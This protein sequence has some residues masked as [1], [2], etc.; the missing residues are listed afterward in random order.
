[1]S[2]QQPQQ[3]IAGDKSRP[4][5]RKRIRLGDLLVENNVISQQQLKHALAEQKVRGTRLGRTLIDLGYIDEKGLL[6]FLSRQLKMPFIDLRHYQLRAQTVK[7]LPETLARRFRAI[8]LEAREQGALVGLADPTDIFAQDELARVLKRPIKPA[9]V[10]EADL[11]DAFDKLYR[12]TDEISSIAEEL[13]EQISQS[14]FD[15]SELDEGV[16]VTD[17]P[18]V[19]LLQSLSLIHI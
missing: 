15:L 11:L 9:L 14:D 19:R 13:G 3:P 16:D 10:R 7:L 18:V 17:A 1:M 2:E 4:P 8:V 12:R 5:V 6:D